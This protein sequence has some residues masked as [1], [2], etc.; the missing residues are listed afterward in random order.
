M[1]LSFTETKLEQV[2]LSLLDGKGYAHYSEKDIERT[3]KEEVL[4]LSD[5]IAYFTAAYKHEKITQG[6]IVTFVGFWRRLVPCFIQ[7]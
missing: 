5:I 3:D 7:K 4:I 1:S 6:E 2:I